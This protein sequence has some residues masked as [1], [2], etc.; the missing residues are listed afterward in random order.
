MKFP[1]FTQIGGGKVHL[2]PE[3]IS[4]IQVQPNNTTLIWMANGRNHHVNDKVHE[5]LEKLGADP[6]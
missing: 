4:E 1:E 6:P 3:Q 2:N 5:V